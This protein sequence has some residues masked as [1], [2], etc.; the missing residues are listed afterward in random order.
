MII[1]LNLLNHPE[2]KEKIKI[3]NKELVKKFYIK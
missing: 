2:M 1:L 3:Y